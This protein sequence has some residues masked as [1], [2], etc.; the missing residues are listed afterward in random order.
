MTRQSRTKNLSLSLTWCIDG[1]D[2]SALAVYGVCVLYTDRQTHTPRER[3]AQNDRR[4]ESRD[5]SADAALAVY[6]ICIL[7]IGETSR[8]IDTQTEER[9]ERERVCARV[10]DAYLCAQTNLKTL[11]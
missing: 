10:C 4:N 2:H 11:E 6:G 5:H 8:H 7:Y 9:S 3:H 1:R